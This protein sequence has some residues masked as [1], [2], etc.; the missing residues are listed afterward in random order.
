MDLLTGIN[1]SDNLSKEWYQMQAVLRV[2]L[3]NFLFFGILA[4]IMIGVKDQNDKRD[5]VHH[6]GWIAKMLIWALLIILMFFLPNVIISAYGQSSAHIWVF[7][8]RIC[9]LARNPSFLYDI[10]VSY[11][12]LH[13]ILHSGRVVKE[14]P[15]VSE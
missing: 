8:W 15:L 1:T 9:L 13:F 6:G 3:G 7:S 11:V 5:A 2:S 12:H 10:G 14:Q 4:V